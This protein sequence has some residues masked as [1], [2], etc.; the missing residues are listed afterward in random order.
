MTAAPDSSFADAAFERARVR[1]EIQR[2]LKP[3]RAQLADLEREQKRLEGEIRCIEMAANPADFRHA[4]ID[5]PHLNAGGRAYWKLVDAGVASFEEVANLTASELL[6]V[7]GIGPT[8]LEIIRQVLE[9]H[10][11][12]LRSAS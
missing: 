2:D 5:D 11:Y 4:M 10:G 9:E 3:L 12:A 7:N 6:A 1:W 8:L